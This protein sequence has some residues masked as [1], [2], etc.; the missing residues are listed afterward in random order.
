MSRQEA[1]RR[2]KESVSGHRT[3]LP[4]KLLDLFA[5]RPAPQHLPPLRKKKPNLAYTGVAQYLEC[6]ADPGDAMYEPSPMDARPKSPRTFRNRELAV[7]ARV[8]I[9]SKA[10]KKERLSKAGAEKV[11]KQIEESTKSWN[12]HK[13]PKLQGDPYK[14]L[15]VARISFDVSDKILRRYFEEYGPIK[16]IKMVHESRTGKFRGYAFIEYEHKAD[17]KDAYK[18]ADGLKI[19]GRRVVVDVE[20]GR[21]VDGWRPR[22]LA[23]G[24]GGQNRVAREPGSLR[25]APMRM[26]PD[27]LARFS[28]D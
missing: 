10:E 22:R 15:F 14:T 28:L 12:P 4:R 13:E 19:E 9:E 18:S 2:L 3:G 11:K 26:E 17:M 8:E 23:G 20:R 25:D 21:T 5:P 16:Q 7:Q 24:L 1:Q 6:F 27:R